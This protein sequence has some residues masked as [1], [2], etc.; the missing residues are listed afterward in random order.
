MLIGGSGWGT[1]FCCYLRSLHNSLVMESVCSGNDGACKP[2][3]SIK[4]WVPVVS[5][6]QLS[7]LVIL[8]ANANANMLSASR[9]KQYAIDQSV[10]TVGLV[11]LVNKYLRGKIK[12][13]NLTLTEIW[14][15]S[16]RFIKQKYYCI[17]VHYPTVC[18]SENLLGQTVQTEQQTL[19]HLELFLD[20]VRGPRP[21]W[22]PALWTLHWTEGFLPTTIKSHVVKI[23]ITWS[24]RSDEN[25]NI[26]LVYT[27]GIKNGTFS[28][29]AGA[30]IKRG[31][32][33]S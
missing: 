10:G 2:F 14:P 21:N 3:W 1:V 30:H 4:T 23:I 19:G 27:K 7:F 15:I 17:T 22:I 12:W 29:L 31:H 28:F 20:Y 18:A 16:D 5:W 11:C 8:S 26:E 9:W 25:N 6:W 33:A 32:R 24:I 13:T